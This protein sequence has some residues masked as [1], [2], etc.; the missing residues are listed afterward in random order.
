MEW[1][2]F[3]RCVSAYS[4]KD[5]GEETALRLR[6]LSTPRPSFLLSSSLSI[7]SRLVSS[8]L[9]PPSFQACAA[10]DLLRA[11]GWSARSRARSPRARLRPKTCQ[12]RCAHFCGPT[13]G[14]CQGAFSYFC[15]GVGLQA[16]YCPLEAWCELG[17]EQRDACIRHL[18]QRRAHYLW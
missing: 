9:P 6:V 10:S 4:Y 15:C 13:Q 18:Y 2:D 17:N 12:G 11:R 7:T 5:G 3:S 16:L 14:L 8:P 1:S